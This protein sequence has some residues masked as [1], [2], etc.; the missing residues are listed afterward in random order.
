MGIK[1]AP[2]T[3]DFKEI[4]VQSSASLFFQIKNEL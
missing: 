4:F 2:V 1:V 3:L